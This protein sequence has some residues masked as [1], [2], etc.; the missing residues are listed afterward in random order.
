MQLQ[1]HDNENFVRNWS[2]RNIELDDRQHSGLDI[3]T[4]SCGVQIW[5]DAMII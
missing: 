4:Q 1:P 5:I 3:V 2:G